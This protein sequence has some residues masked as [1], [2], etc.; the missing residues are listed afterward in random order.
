MVSVRVTP[1]AARC[2]RTVLPLPICEICA[3]ACP[4][5]A[6]TLARDGAPRIDPSACTGC[7]ACAVACPETAI[8]I[9]PRA[10]PVAPIWRLACSGAQE[11]RAN[12]ACLNALT[13]DDLAEAW[14]AGVRVIEPRA[15]E[16]ARCARAGG[17]PFAETLARFNRFAHARGLEAIRTV[18]AQVPQ[19]GRLR[20][21]LA[22]KAPEQRKRR[23]VQATQGQGGGADIGALR[24]FLSIRPRG[25]EEALFPYSPVID[26][27][28]CEGC[29]ACVR[30]CPTG[31]LTRSADASHAQYVADPARCTG[32]GWC[33]ALCEHEAVS[34]AFDVRAADAVELR[35]QVCPECKVRH[36]VP[37]AREMRGGTCSIC[38][39]RAQARPDNLVL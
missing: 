19:W 1:D 37:A 17:T 32:C 16:C 26:P 2:A 28:R 35:A 8:G 7:G 11:A 36:H 5:E 12:I 3:D 29:D 25:D 14:L 13:L 30:G 34:V 9:A 33:I 22:P 21:R 31:A 10:E 4:H 15:H 23:M 39:G 27:L 18:P 24:R 38:R 20:R 6:V